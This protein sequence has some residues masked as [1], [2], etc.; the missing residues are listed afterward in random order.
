MALFM[1]CMICTY[2]H[3]KSLLSFDLDSLVFMSTEV[4]EVQIE[5]AKMQDWINCLTVSVLKNFLGREKNGEKISVGL[6]TYSKENGNF[7][8]GDTLFL[9]IE[10]PR[11]EWLDKGLQ[12][13][14]VPSGV[15]VVAN[16]QVTGMIQNENP[17]P[18]INAVEDGPVED[19]RGKLGRAVQHVA[20]FKRELQMNASDSKWLLTQ[21]KERP[22]PKEGFRDCI[23]VQLCRTLAKTR[24]KTSINE[25][26]KLRKDPY[27][28]QSLES[29]Q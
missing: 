7:D 4:L 20:R 23:A 14:P 13:W 16:G 3:A 22:L 1:N 19:F 17:G 28:R 8:K 18:Y 25:A 5:S 10:R 15:K 21:L 27:E 24:D 6:S 26:L 12:Y 29:E 11:K 2:A 9:F